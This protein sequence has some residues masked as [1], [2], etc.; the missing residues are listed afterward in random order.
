MVT[1]LPAI[2][3]LEVQLCPILHEELLPGVPSVPGPTPRVPVMQS[4][5]SLLRSAVAL[6]H[7]PRLISCV[8]PHCC[9]TPLSTPFIRMF[10]S[11]LEP[12]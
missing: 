2:H 7:Q 12:L 6:R 8:T 9:V 3:N 11:L 5:V 1:V 10:E 4:H